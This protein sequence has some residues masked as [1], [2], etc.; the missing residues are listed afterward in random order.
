MA[1][2]IGDAIPLNIN[3]LRKM[4]AV[5]GQQAFYI[6]I[7]ISAHYALPE[8][9]AAA[10][11]NHLGKGFIEFLGISKLLKSQMHTVTPIVA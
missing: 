5:S 1:R 9:A 7:Y 8:S 10:C 6:I 4:P 11:S 2:E 3:D